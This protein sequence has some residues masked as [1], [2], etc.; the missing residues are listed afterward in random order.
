MYVMLYYRQ[1]SFLSPK[2]FTDLSGAHSNSLL[3]IQNVTDKA[4]YYMSVVGYSDAKIILSSRIT[5]LS[6][7]KHAILN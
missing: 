2:C 3:L 7:Q 6:S 5:R 1:E 4:S